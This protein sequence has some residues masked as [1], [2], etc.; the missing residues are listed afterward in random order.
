MPNHTREPSLTD[1][2]ARA[3]VSPTTVSRVLNNRGYLSQHTKDRVAQAI[4]ELQ[5]RPN[6]I[7]RSLLGQR[8]RTVGVIV[9]TVALPFF[10]EIAAGVERALATRGYR[11]LLCNSMGRTEAEREYLDQLRGNRVDG[12][13]S[14]AHNDSIPEYATTQL[15]VVTIDRELAP[16]I[17]NV[18]ADNRAGGRLATELLLNRGSRRPVLFTSTSSTRN[19]REA[20]YR[21][22]LSE[23][24]IEPLV[25]TVN[26]HTPEPERSRQI[27]A[28]LDQHAAAIDAVFATDDLMAGTVLEWARRAGRRVPDDL[29]VI[30]FDGTEAVR[31]AMPW[32]STVQQPIAALCETAVQRLLGLIDSGPS[33]GPES[34][35]PPAELPVTLIEG[36]TT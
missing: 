27:H 33:N 11:T 23:A 15:P 5:Y 6:Q 36:A 34:A 30:G 26:F 12:V 7:A 29:R 22:V 28:A 3:G 31:R 24:G 25:V 20:G 32:L 1:V 35:V 14:G 13:I 19:L 21:E 16:H 17:P 2:A 10:G 4:D 8:T 9:P 18:R